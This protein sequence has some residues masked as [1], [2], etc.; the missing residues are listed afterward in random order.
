[1]TDAALVRRTIERHR[2]ETIYHAAAYKHVPLVEANVV[3]S[4]DNNVFGTLVLAELA[5]KLGVQRFVLISSDKAVRPTNVMGATKR[6]AELIL[7]AHADDPGC[8]CVFTMV[9]F[10]NVLDSSGSVMRLFRRQIAEGGPV[11]VTDPDV[12][13]YFMSIPEAV[14]LVLHAAA[15]AKG[16]EVFVLD[17]GEPVRI[18]ELARSIIRLSGLEIKDQSNPDGDIAI[19]YTG[20][21][22]GEKAYEELLIDGSQTETDHP[23]IGRSEEPFL[24]ADDLAQEL[25]AMKLAM[26]AADLVAI[27]AILSRVVEGYREPQVSA[28]TEASTPPAAAAIWAPASRTLH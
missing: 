4:I 15:M 14:E 19:A 17:M 12:I 28:G 25:K 16:G 2:I 20:L 5:R 1:M 7:Q 6:L 8:E 23:R 21:R 9:R 3:A 11:T 27:R 13:R 22:P 26:D 18:D 10:G 24:K